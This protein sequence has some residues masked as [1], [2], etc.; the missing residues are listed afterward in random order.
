MTAKKKKVASSAAH[1]G[2]FAMNERN[3]N[4]TPVAVM[5]TLNNV[6][7]NIIPSLLYCMQNLESTRPL[8]F[9]S[10][11]KVWSQWNESIYPGDSKLQ[12]NN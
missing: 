5:K 6:K 7:R 8:D 10:K 12:A 3:K 4:T 2:S 9:Q 11:K 1:V